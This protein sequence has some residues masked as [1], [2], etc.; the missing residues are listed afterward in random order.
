MKK[1]VI[2]LLYFEQET[3]CS[4]QREMRFD[5]FVSLYDF[6]NRPSFVLGLSAGRINDVR[7]ER[8]FA[9]SEV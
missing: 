7:V 9:D 1:L 2:V 4:T 5:S 8:E 3:D 6:I